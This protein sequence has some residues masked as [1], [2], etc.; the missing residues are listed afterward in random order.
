MYNHV[1]TKSA[2]ALPGQVGV[3][4]GQWM[5]AAQHSYNL[6]LDLYIL[7]YHTGVPLDPQKKQT[8]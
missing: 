5:V 2:G 3:V 7:L 6:H 4:Q 1:L 8:R